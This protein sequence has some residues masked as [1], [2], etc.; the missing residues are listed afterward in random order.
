[1]LGARSW[2]RGLCPDKES[3]G[4]WRYLD[5]PKDGLLQTSGKLVGR[6]QG[7]PSRQG[8]QMKNRDELICAIFWNP[9][10]SISEAMEEM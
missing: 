6:S 10:F 3:G 9:Q 4:E 2:L 7:G 5:D 8:E 1:M